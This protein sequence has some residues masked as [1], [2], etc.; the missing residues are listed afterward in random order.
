MIIFLTKETGQETCICCPRGYTCTNRKTPDACPPGSYI[1]TDYCEYR[2]KC[3]ECSRGY[4]QDKSGQT[5]CMCCP[6]GHQCQNAHL[7]PVP[8]EPGTMSYTYCSDRYLCK[9]CDRGYYQEKAGQPECNCCPAGHRCG[10][11]DRLPIPCEP[12]TFQPES[13]GCSSRYKCYDCNGGYYQDE[14]GQNKCNEC[15][16]GYYCPEGSTCPIPCPAGTYND[17]WRNTGCYTCSGSST[18]VGSTTCG[19]CTP[20]PSIQCA[21]I[22]RFLN[23]HQLSKT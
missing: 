16:P 17:R 12:G 1:N 20:G 22:T 6:P 2:T 19:I 15:P 18:C 10:R 9:Q 4:Y 3:S 8:C 13:Y 23:L 21:A 14:S 5:H 11:T 7:P